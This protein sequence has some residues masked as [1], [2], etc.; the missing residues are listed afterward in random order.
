MPSAAIVWFRQDLRL[1]DNPALQ[2]AL[3]RDAYLI[4]LYIYSPDEEGSWPPGSATRWWLHQ[5]LKSL[6]EDLKHFKSRL[7]VRAGNSID[8]LRKVIDETDAR[9]VLWNRRY[10]PACVIRDELVA[11]QLIEDGIEI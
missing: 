8:E 3:K 7:I 2:F 10:E 4:P 5:S 9:L 1:E 11:N 6:S